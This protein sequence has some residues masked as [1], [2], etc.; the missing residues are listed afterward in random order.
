MASL[1]G[2]G[3]VIEADVLVL[4]GGIAGCLGAIQ[5]KTLD[6]DV[7]LVEKGK[8]GKSGASS[9]TGGDFAVFNPEWGHDFD[10]WMDCIA[11]GTEYV[12]NR[13]W[14]EIVLRDSYS[15]FSDLLSYGVPFVRDDGD[16]SGFYRK[17]FGSTE[18]LQVH[19]TEVMPAL[20]K[21]AIESGVRIFDKIVITDL[22]KNEGRVV[23]AVGFHRISGDFYTFIARAT[24]Q[25]MGN[26]SFGVA[27]YT[28]TTPGSG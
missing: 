9:F 28:Q 5:A 23:G 7:V 13:K 10:F 16:K 2:Y 14:V 15:V 3:K 19:A 25:A 24:I 1:E 8:V 4:G 21:K 6:A 11:R 26:V 20:R 18:T 27:A 22:L 17:T 12:N